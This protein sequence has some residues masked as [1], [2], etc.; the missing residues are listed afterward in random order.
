[1]LG[2]IVPGNG[3]VVGV[4]IARSLRFNSPDTP[5]LTN[6]SVAV[7][8]NDKKFTQSFWIKR[9]NLGVL[10]SVLGPI[11]DFRIN[12]DDTF[13]VIGANGTTI[14]RNSA[15]KLRDPHAW[16]HFIIVWDTA[17]A[18]AADRL[19]VFLN[20]LEVTNW[21]TNNAVALN[22][23]HAAN[24]ASTTRY[25]STYDG[26][27]WP[28]DCLMADFQHI[29]G[30]ALAPSS[31]GE[32][33]DTT[34]EWGPK[35]YAGSF[36]A[37]GSH[38]DFSD[39]SNTT[40]AT[41]GK[42][43]SGNNNDW[44]PSGF[45]VAAGAGNDSL[46]DTPTN[47]D[48]GTV[49]GNFC[50]L[51]SINKHQHGN[52]ALTNCGLTFTG[53]SASFHFYALGSMP[54]VAGEKRA[55]EMTAGADP[56]YLHV[57]G[58]GVANAL[59]G[60][61][62]AADEVATSAQIFTYCMDG[63]K[64]T[65]GSPTA[66]GAAFTTADKVI[67]Y[68]DATDGDNVKVWFEKNGAIQGGGD[69][70]AGTSPAFSGIKAPVLPI[71]VAVS[72]AAAGGHHANFGQR[73]FGSA[74]RSGYSPICATS[75]AAPG[76]PNPRKK[77]AIFDRA[78]TGAAGSKSGLLLQPN[79]LIIKPRVGTTGQTNPIITSLRGTGKYKS[80]NGGVAEVADAQSI[81]AFNSDGYSFGTAA[82]LNANATQFLDI[83]LKADPANGIEV[84]TWVGDGGATKAIPHNLAKKPGMALLCGMGATSW[85]LWHKAFA[86][87]AHFQ[88]LGAASAADAANT[89]TPL[90]A[91]SGSSI[92]VTNNATNNLNSNGVVYIAILFADGPLWAGGAYTGN[93]STDGPMLTANFRPAFVGVYNANNQ[94]WYAADRARAANYNGN[95]AQEVN[96][97]FLSYGANVT[98]GALFDFLSNGAKLRNSGANFN[99][100]GSTKYWFALAEAAGQYARAA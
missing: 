85:Y 48:D 67:C 100:S 83:A 25:I 35:V 72:N 50:V 55:F 23:V 1:M 91:V 36:G 62:Y 81:T 74:L 42:D 21:A 37:N 13:S 22:F 54:I 60:G 12:A 66:Y 39:N 20:G 73:P 89:N 77:I 98:T 17:Q 4:R 80:M 97:M 82:A 45:S 64:R 18:N 40:S 65:A 68:V 59:F 75:K 31:L 49:H 30:Q 41:L 87:D 95:A 33:D 93:A 57:S 26:A 24:K 10:Q 52:A 61:P 99:Q 76:E 7:P 56:S 34:G 43:R 46:T 70:V 2:A 78:G 51:S 88:T 96:Y 15:F 53:L 90:S 5:K 14:Y 79:A 28:A 3:S 11:D 27:T 6:V 16:Y 69:P 92:T 38:P 63:T 8:T 9:G 86:S 29:D 94:Y 58:I 84:V 47:Y 19:R 71:I 44:T 32:F